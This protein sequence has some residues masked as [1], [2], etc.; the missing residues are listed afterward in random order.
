MS[1]YIYVSVVEMNHR[2]LPL[3][4]ISCR[5]RFITTGFLRA[6]TVVI[7]HNVR[8]LK[9]WQVWLL[10]IAVFYTGLNIF[11]IGQSP[12]PES[13]INCDVCVCYS[14]SRNSLL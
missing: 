14:A 9:L 5:L 8:H 10:I 6:T 7:R 11:I 2:E 4:P 1:A 12:S 3:C 13:S